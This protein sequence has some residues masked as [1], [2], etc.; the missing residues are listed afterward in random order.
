MVLAC[1]VP[2]QTAGPVP[3][4]RDDLPKPI[5]RL[6]TCVSR[7][8]WT[9][10][11]PTP[12]RA[13]NAGVILL[14]NCPPGGTDVAEMKL[15]HPRPQLAYYLSRGVS[16][17]GARRLTFPYLNPDGSMT[18]LNVLP[19]VPAIGWT[20]RAHNSERHGG[21]AV[22]D[23]DRLRLPNNAFHLSVHFA[24]GDRPHVTDVAAIW[25]VEHGEARLIYWAETG[26]KL[27]GLTGEDI[28]PQYRTVLD[29]RPAN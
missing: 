13:G 28:R 2:A 14:V 21:L 19:R 16:G 29:R 5:A 15:R 12:E 4:R 10:Y 24:P 25:Q 11:R 26:D 1:T 17:V 8:G 6:H 9:Q 27:R 22:F 3:V 7:D 20:T 18:T 23:R